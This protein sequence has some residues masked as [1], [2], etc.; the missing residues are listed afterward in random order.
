[1]NLKIFWNQLSKRRHKQL[2]LLLMLMILASLVEVVSIGAILPFLGVLTSPEQVFQYPLLQP[3]IQAIGIPNSAH[4]LFPVTILFIAAIL[5]AGSVRLLL[6]YVIT[7]YT[8]LKY[9]KAST[10]TSILLL[11]SPITTLLSFFFLKT[12]LVV[13]QAIGI[14]LIIGGVISMILLEKSYAPISST[15]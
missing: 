13:P 7:W 5:I 3:I 1:M 4:L 12:H 14:L 8:G 10:A 15:A 2:Y 9:T 6:L 11:G